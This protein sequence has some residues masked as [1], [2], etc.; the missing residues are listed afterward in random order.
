M[1][2]SGAKRVF[3]S[4]STDASPVRPRSKIPA[5]RTLD[6]ESS[7]GLFAAP[8]AD[9][10]AN[11]TQDP[12][13]P[14]V[15]P[16]ARLILSS[17]ARTAQ[18]YTPGN[19]MPI[20]LRLSIELHAYA[21]PWIVPIPATCSLAGAVALVRDGLTERGIGG[22]GYPGLVGLEVRGRVLDAR[23]WEKL[24]FGGGVVGVLLVWSA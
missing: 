2:K 6:I 16:A 3:E 9:V 15:A 5:R 4:S 22:E 18:F 24:L 21:P 7:P 11:S 1:T 14:A 13:T 23:A 12:S 17:A 19:T 20:F 8:E 10:A